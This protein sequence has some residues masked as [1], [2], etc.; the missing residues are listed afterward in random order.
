MSM[1]SVYFATSMILLA[2]LSGC[3]VIQLVQT[4]QG[5]NNARSGYQ[6]YEAG[7]SIKAI[8][9]HTPVFKDYQVAFISVDVQPRK[10]DAAQMKAALEA[11]YDRSVND[12]AQ[13]LGLSVACFPY[14]QA[15]VE[16]A[17]D[18]LVI[19][20]TE[21]KGST[22]TT[23]MSGENIH[24]TVK[25]IDKKTARVLA[26]EEFKPLKG[27]DNMIGI[28]TI[29][30]MAK[31]MGNGPASTGGSAPSEADQKAWNDKVMKMSNEQKYP[32]VTPE[33]KAIIEKG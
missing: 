14:D 26:E 20:V 24:A 10:A 19:Q 18:A 17:T 27:Y 25:Y 22:L 15:K 32:I 5:V 28:M 33:E 12:M 2:V 11:A 4:V 31:L 1:K 13:R 7:S 8:K 29:S 3:S 9:D 6:V 23:I 21:V 30:A 16:S